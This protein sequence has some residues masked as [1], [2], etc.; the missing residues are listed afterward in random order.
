MLYEKIFVLET[1]SRQL[2]DN[3]NKLNS[4]IDRDDISY[5]LGLELQ[6]DLLDLYN[7]GYSFS[8]LDKKVKK[9]SKN[10]LRK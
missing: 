8:K 5:N 2:E 10:Y 7:K 4:L 1:D 3:F 9:L 6:D